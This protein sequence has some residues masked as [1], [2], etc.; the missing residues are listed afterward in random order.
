MNAN[1]PEFLRKL[2]YFLASFLAIIGGVSAICMTIVYHE[3]FIT[4][5]SVCVCCA[6]IPT[7]AN[8]IKKLIE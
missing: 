2:F 3:W 5:G 8:W 4:F 6:A 1:I 7:V